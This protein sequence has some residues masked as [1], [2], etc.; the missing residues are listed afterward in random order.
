MERSSE[1]REHLF[2]WEGHWP[3]TSEDGDSPWRVRLDLDVVEGRL[4]CTHFEMWMGATEAGV[5]VTTTALRGVPLGSLV[6]GAT[7]HVRALA[8]QYEPVAAVAEVIPTKPPRMGRPPVYNA[9]H[10]KGVAATYRK[11]GGRKPTMA[12]ANAFGVSRSTAAGWV[13]RCRELGELGDAV[14]RRRGGERETP[15]DDQKQKGKR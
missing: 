6:E 14:A 5:P 4:E 2:Q 7:H 9:E 1:V 10:W 13:R 8:E 15:T 12:V 11:A 3:P